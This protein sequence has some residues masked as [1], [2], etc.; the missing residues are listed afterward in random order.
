VNDS[1]GCLKRPDVASGLAL[2][3]LALFAWVGASEL[4]IGTLHQPGAGFLPKHLGLLMAVLGALLFV[5]GCRTR[6]G[7][8]VRLWSDRASFTRVGGMLA[9]LI[10]Y[11][12]V[13][14]TAGYLLTTA[15]LFFV[16]LH[17]I[18]RQGW[19]VTLTV[20]GL[21]AGG[22]YLLFARWLM[23]SLP[24][25]AWAPLFCLVG[26]YSTSG[27]VADVFIMVCFGLLGYLIRTFKFEAT[28]LILALILGK[29]MEESP[30]QALGISQ[31]S[32]AIF[33]NRPISL[34][35]LL[36]TAASLAVPVVRWALPKR[37]AHS[38]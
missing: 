22:S 7:S 26:A 28:P 5:R 36:A 33:A 13:V 25:G 9:A 17:W 27:Q 3:C 12:L 6:A 1:Q 30:R 19:A 8:V 18:G 37:N 15:A 35:L 21:G 20:A 4:P 29:P 14:E 11:V 2:V 16:T 38:A 31:G 34:V 32:F 24:G 23:V 10:G